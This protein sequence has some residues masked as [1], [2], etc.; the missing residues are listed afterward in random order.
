VTPLWLQ[1]PQ[2]PLKLRLAVDALAKELP[3]VME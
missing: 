1:T 3:K 2:L